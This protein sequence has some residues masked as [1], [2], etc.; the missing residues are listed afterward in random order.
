VNSETNY[1]LLNKYS[2]IIYSN[3]DRVFA[4][5]STFSNRIKNFG[6]QLGLRAESS[7]NK[8]ILDRTQT[9][10]KTFPISLFPSFFLSQKLTDNA[11]L[12]MNYSRRVNRRIFG[13]CSPLSITP[14]P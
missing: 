12:Q 9:F 3:E 4:A 14:I 13:N 10:R 2:S 7:D 5:Y 1:T 6:Y 11:D 8:G